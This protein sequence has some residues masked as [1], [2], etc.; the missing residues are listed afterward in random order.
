M[1]FLLRHADQ[2]NYGIPGFDVF[3]V[4][5]AITVVQAAEER[6]APLIMMVYE[7]AFKAIPPEVYIPALR[8]IAEK[9]KL[10]IAL[11]LDHGTDLVLLRR[12]L[13]L[14]FRYVMFDGSSL[15]FEDNVR[16]S[17]EA[18]EYAAKF[19]ATVEAELGH[20]G[21]AS[22]YEIDGS[23]NLTEPAAAVEFVRRTGVHCLAVAVGTAHGQ[24]KGV[25]KLHFDRLAEI[26]AKVDIPLVLHGGSGTGIDN[27][28]RSIRTGI[29]KINIYT[30]LAVAA[31]TAIAEEIPR[32]AAAKKRF[33][34]LEQ[35]AIGQEAMKRKAIEYLDAF[36]ASGLAEKFDRLA[37]FGHP[38]RPV[39]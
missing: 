10:P 15:P 9:S 22:K 6:N 7:G 28:Q 36:G 2:H 12:V 16:L 30:D 23:T 21:D 13:D 1:D 39:A 34:I 26:D 24:Y 19:G 17:R 11:H 27:I 18:V 3:N 37:P 25:P 38:P 14:G 31:E 5:D 33:E 32:K 4:E 8:T 29:R 20:V 35:R